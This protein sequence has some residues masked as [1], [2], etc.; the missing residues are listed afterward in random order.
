MIS[1]ESSQSM[2]KKTTRYHLAVQPNMVPYTRSPAMERDHS[3]QQNGDQ[4]GSKSLPSRLPGSGY[5]FEE[6]EDCAELGYN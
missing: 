3:A 4:K 2:S 1:V 5:T 6:V